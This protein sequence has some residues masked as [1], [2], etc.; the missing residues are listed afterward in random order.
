[1][2]HTGTVLFTIAV[3]LG[4]TVLVLGAADHRL[5]DTV[6]EPPVMVL[7]IDGQTYRGIQA[8]YCWAQQDNASRRCVEK[9]RAD[10]LAVRAALVSRTVERN[11]TV[12]V[13][14]L[15]FRSPDHLGYIL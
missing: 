12:T 2:A 8:D 6:P 14:T 1:M 11:T 15:S 7:E 3:S 5:Q 10:K 13:R 9:I 4:L